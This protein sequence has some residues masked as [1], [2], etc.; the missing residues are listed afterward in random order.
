MSPKKS[1]TKSPAQA[2]SPQ[3]FAKLGQMQA[4]ALSEAQR[5]LSTFLQQ[6]TEDWRSRAEVERELATELTNNLM[7]AKTL[8]DAAAAYQQWMARRIAQLVAISHPLPPFLG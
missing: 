3:D 7:A 6:A 4:D 2:V 1:S 5:E 8:P